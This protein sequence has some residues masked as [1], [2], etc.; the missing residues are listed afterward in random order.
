MFLVFF[1]LLARFPKHTRFM[2]LLALSHMIPTTFLII[3]MFSDMRGTLLELQGVHRSTEPHPAPS[4]ATAARHHLLFPWARPKPPELKL[5]LV[6][7]M[8]LSEDTYKPVPPFGGW[9]E[10]YGEVVWKNCLPPC[11]THRQ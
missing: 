8:D 3:C 10:L 11:E 7:L 4:C 6:V 2:L 5:V 9:L 1:C